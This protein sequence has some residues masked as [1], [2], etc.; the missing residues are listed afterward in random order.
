MKKFFNDHKKLI[1]MSLFLVVFISACTSPRGKDGKIIPEQLIALNTSFSDCIK[2]SWFNIFVWPIAQLINLVA[3]VSDAGIGVIVVTIILNAGIAALSIKQQV[4]MQKMQM[5]QPELMRI[6][7]KYQGK[8]DQ[9]S[10]MRQAQELQRVY[11]KHKINPFGSIVVT[12][13]QFPVIFAVYQAVMRAETVVNGSFLGISLNQTPIDGFK[14]MNW[15]VIIIFILMIVFQIISFKLPQYLQKQQQK[16]SKVKTK[17]YAQPK[18]QQSTMQTSMNMMLY[19]NLA[20]CIIF[21][22]N[23]PL[24]M[25]FYWMVSSVT[26]VAQ[27]LIIQKFFIKDQI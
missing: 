18:S 14:A 20:M 24:G 19:M 13:I 9:N 27:N 15:G 4:A 16:K 26:R 25:S 1:M 7:A 2:L 11:D 22:I 6:Q 8:T 17:E 21:S 12:F 3:N 5:I 10:K 23:W